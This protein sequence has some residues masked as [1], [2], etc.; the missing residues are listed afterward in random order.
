MIQ[1]IETSSE[2]LEHMK[3]DVMDQLSEKIYKAYELGCKGGKR[4]SQ[5]LIAQ[6]YQ[7]G[8]KDGFDKAI[9]DDEA[10]ESGFAAGQEQAHEEINVNKYIEQGRNEAWEAAKKII[11]QNSASWGM[12][13]M[14]EIFGL[15]YSTDIM[16]DLSASEAIEKISSYEARKKQEE[17]EIR[18]GDEVLFNG[19]AKAV[20][21]S[22]RMRG[23]ENYC[24]IICADGSGGECE[25]LKLKKTGRTFQEIVEVLKKMQ[26]GD[27]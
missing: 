7:R 5:D 11:S 14:K 23:L 26:E 19:I 10:Y 4:Q 25:K 21:L 27:K 3:D 9:A 20:V 8:F 1:T 17:D 24:F 12:K 2:Y 18:V 22:T 13:D 6:A 16:L 15:S